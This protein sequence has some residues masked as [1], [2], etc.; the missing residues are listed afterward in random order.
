MDLKSSTTENRPE[1]SQ[2][3]KWLHILVGKENRECVM[4]IFEAVLILV[5]DLVKITIANQT[6]GRSAAQI[7]IQHLFKDI[8]MVGLLLPPRCTDDP[9]VA[10]L[11][12]RV[13]AVL[14]LVTREDFD[15]ISFAEA[16]KMINNLSDITLDVSLVKEVVSALQEASHGSDL[17]T[18]VAV[19]AALLPNTA[20]EKIDEAL[21]SPASSLPGAGFIDTLNKYD[22]ELG[23]DIIP[24]EVV[25]GPAID[26]LIRTARVTGLIETEDAEFLRREVAAAK[27]LNPLERMK[28]FIEK[29][30]GSSSSPI[31]T[32]P[33]LPPPRRRPVRIEIVP[34]GEEIM[35]PVP[36]GQID[37]GTIKRMK[38]L[39]GIT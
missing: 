30:M 37:E 35:A 3:L 28:Q 7:E 19:A 38:T 31:E 1:E 39:A 12:D 21:N 27:N 16:E 24:D 8:V 18:Q 17:E 25:Q 13:Y 10:A 4:A 23:I 33:E 34:R 32:D 22:N 29:V 9:Q 15:D 2:L 26:L 6:I 14:S 11:F 5:E 20:L 36:T